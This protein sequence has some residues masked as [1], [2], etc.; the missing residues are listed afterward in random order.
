ML[1]IEFTFFDSIEPKNAGYAEGDRK[2]GIG[3]LSLTA[4]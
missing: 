4:Y 3:L 2:L 1:R